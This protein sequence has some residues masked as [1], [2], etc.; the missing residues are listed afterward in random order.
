[1]KR[2]DCYGDD[3]ILQGCFHCGGR[4]DTDDHSPPKVLLDK[5]YPAEMITVPSCYE[6]NNSASLD[7]AY[8]ACVIEC[9]VTGNVS[10]EGVARTVIQKTLA[11]I[12]A[13][14]SQ[15]NAIRTMGEDGSVFHP[16]PER[17]RREIVKIA[18][19]H[20]TYELHEHFEEDP[21]SVRCFP[22]QVL[23]E[24]QREEFERPAGGM[25]WPEVGSR[26]MQRLVEGYHSD[27][28]G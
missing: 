3:R 26:A 17:I 9:T 11:P 19:A 25:M 1:M 23:S 7:E 10:T 16:D 24:G 12:P 6:C 4:P 13:L 28:P 2:V 21:I 20:A 5:P 18:R 8:L 22:P 14:T 15:M 27:R